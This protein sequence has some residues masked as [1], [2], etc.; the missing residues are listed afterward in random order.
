MIIADPLPPKWTVS[1]F[2]GY[3]LGRLGDIPPRDLL[4]IA[5][6]PYG[7]PVDVD[8]EPFF[9]IQTLRRG[10][11]ARMRLKPIEFSGVIRSPR[12]EQTIS[13]AV[14][15]HILAHASGFLIIRPTVQSASVSLT[16]GV[17]TE[18]LCQLDNALWEVAYPL[19]W[20]VPGTAEPIEG[21]VRNL[22]NWTFL[23]L[24][25]RVHGREGS[26]VA[27]WAVEGIHGCERLHAMAAKREITYPFPVSF[28]IQWEI[29]D[30]ALD[31]LVTSDPRALATDLARRLFFP[32]DPRAD[33][34]PVDLGGG[35]PEEWWFLGESQALTLTSRGSIDR[36]LD[37][38]D[39]E[40]TQLLEF[41]TLRRTTLSCV[42]RDTQ[43]VL[44]ERLPVSRGQIERWQHI[45]ASTTDDYIV[46]AKM[47]RLLAPAL[48]HHAA[49]VRIRDLAALEA[50][51]RENL[52]WFQQRLDTLSDWTGGL[53]GATVGTAALVLSL[54]EVVQTLLATATGEKVDDVLDAH[55]P[56]FSSIMLGLMVVTFFLSLVGI[57]LITSRMRP[58]TFRVT[59][60]WRGRR[61]PGFQPTMDAP[62]ATAERA[63]PTD[64]AA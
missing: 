39:P 25:E 20:H 3:D 37:V 8:S 46:H 24:Y 54:Q 50:Q 49:D 13:G 29:I 30:A 40:R 42:Q 31:P 62:R 17:G 34:A 38:V 45:V 36:R 6:P 7:E 51:V 1:W 35:I 21:G 58:F 61:P 15:V 28:G 22:M 19:R 63:A 44:T 47:G 4:R 52:G 33:I 16:K 18:V 56:L 48:A 26:P 53:V 55:G 27:A 14:T 5:L 57:R 23:D 64:T 60:R 9:D 59:S 43:R 12:G 41:I 2:R 32:D 11:V 10:H